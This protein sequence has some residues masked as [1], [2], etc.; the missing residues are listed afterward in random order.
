MNKLLTP[1]SALAWLGALWLIYLL[2]LRLLG[3]QLTPY[4]NLFMFMSML[5]LMLARIMSRRTKQRQQD[6]SSLP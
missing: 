5:L 6:E 4:D 3:A 1:T 2:G